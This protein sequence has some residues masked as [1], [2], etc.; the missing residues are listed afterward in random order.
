MKACAYLIIVLSANSLAAAE[1]RASDGYRSAALP[2]IAAH[3]PGFTRLPSNATGV[4][5][6]NH[7]AND[8]S[9][10]NRN[11]LSGSGVAAGDFDGD[12]LCDLFFCRL[13]GPS[14]L[15]RNLGS[16][17]FEDVTAK[18]SVA[19]AGQ[20][21][22]AAS[23]ADIDGD[24][25]LDLIVNALG[26][27]TRIFQNDG[28]G[29]FTE[30]TQRAGVGSK[31]GS[32]SMALADIDGDGDLD[33]YVA[34]FRPTTTMDRPGTKFTI[35]FVEGRQVVTA[36]DGVPT[37]SPELVGQFTVNET[38]TIL[39]SGEVD[40]LYLNNGKGGFTSVSFTNGA[41]LDEAGQPLRE[42]PRDWGLAVQFRDF[43]GD[44][45]PDIYVCNDLF[46]PDR[47]W[48]N[49]GRGKFRALPTLALRNTSTFS[50]GV[51]FADL[52]RDGHTD[53]FV[54]DMLSPDH[55]MR[56]VQTGQSSPMWWPVGVFETRPQLSRNTLQVGR[57]DGTFAEIAHY[58]GVEASDWSWGP[59]FL[60]VDLDGY[61]DILVSNGQ[62]RDFQN[63]DWGERIAQA[64]AGKRLTM[65]DVLEL[66]KNI[67]ALRTPNIAYRN[68][69]D[70]TFEE[71]GAAW[72]FNTPGIS[73]GMCLADLDN[74]GDMDVVMNNLNEEAGVY[75]NQ[76]S[77]ARVAVRLKGNAP[78]TAGIGARITVRGGAVGR[79]D[80][81]MICGGRYL[82]GD[83]AMRVFAASSATN[84]LTIEVTWR[85]G[86]RSV[87]SNAEPNRI[88][89]IAESGGKPSP[90]RKAPET[91]PLF[92]DVSHLIQHRHA[93][94][95]F[96]DFERQPLLPWRLSQLG[97]GV[98]WHDVDNDGWE[99]LVI[100]SGKGGTLG[101]YHN[102]TKG[103]F[104]RWTNG[105]LNRAVSRDQTSVVGMGGL[106][107]VGSSNY[108]D[109]LTNGGAIR[110]YD[111]GRGAS[112]EAVLTPT[113]STGPLAMADVDGDG[114]LDLFVGGRVIPGK[115][116]GPATSQL[117]RNEG[118]RF[119]PMQKW[120]QLGLVSGA[121][122]SDLDGDGHP[123]LVLACEWGPI[124]V[125]KFSQGK[126]E[127][128]TEPLGLA[129][130]KG[131]WHGVTTGDLDGDGRLDILASNW[132][133]NSP[134]RVSERHP[135]RLHYTD[136]DDNGSME[137]VE[138]RFE[139]EM[140]KEVP[141]RGLRSMMMA[142]PL[143]RQRTPT[144]EAYANASVAE[145][146]GESATAAKTLEVNTLA[147]MVFLN[148]GDRFEGVL[149]PP[150]AQWA[151]SFGVAVADVDG[152]GNEDVFLSQ[153]LFATNLE[154]GRNDAGR[155]LWLKGDGKGGLK[156]VPGNESGVT[157]YGEQRGCALAD[158][159]GDGRVDLT[160]TQN[161][162][163]TK[164]L[165]NMGAKAGL[166]VRLKGSDGNPHAVGASMRLIFGERRGPVREIHA[167]SGYLSQDGAVQVMATPE[168]PTRLWV[169]WPGGQ[170]VSADVPAGAREIE[171]NVEGRLRKVR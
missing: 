85:N 39:Q 56:Q 68:R 65:K 107:L 127:E 79:Q 64:Q 103:G 73:Q 158:Y 142:M 167:G 47:A 58:A 166:R 135:R 1:W 46:T 146:L 6:A 92:E 60:D 163:S 41:F 26:N 5:F 22:T 98:A 3:K 70:L 67:P 81:E 4:T 18:A 150:E 148:R 49:D 33:L 101:V 108:E 140:K 144:F 83:D 2:T 93:E 95:A 117:L 129:K 86:T 137:I 43:T 80:Q 136:V 52:N 12:G 109:G 114:D 72:G 11:L 44:G 130:Y 131:L 169:R 155:G 147:A 20:D 171:V 102:D 48:V 104:T 168:T 35:N 112:G 28:G 128:Q 45:A 13:D 100:G 152:D 77:G 91:K 90:E 159:D 120:E 74:D 10:T 111:V 27:G 21:S 124:R 19:C 51:D 57:G 30:V 61:E 121:V 113:A 139:P 42:P 88:Y 29:S 118:G 122:F 7:L 25:D 165:K 96:N 82:S 59:I 133:L 63:A 151:P 53:F 36:V 31:T 164:L 32:M 110:I 143:V 161:G 71:F 17:K 66:T 89:E 38:G 15:Y 55:R 123:E 134:Y 145:I 156:A 24:G 106:L 115:Y 105:P 50:M 76:G 84:K 126:Y 116:P 87:V 37:T 97:P 138:S 94:E 9:I 153:N 154:M 160:V 125:F 162:T 34:N 157:I 99:D 170:T 8:R 62:L 16:W 23:F 69:G 78:N 75:R 54:V 132:G 14:V 149:L 40:A 141:E 119:V